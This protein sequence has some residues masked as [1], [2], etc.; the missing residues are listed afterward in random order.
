MIK[1]I[2]RVRT[3]ERKVE[4]ILLNATPREPSQ[5]GSVRRESAAV[6]FVSGGNKRRFHPRDVVKLL[7]AATP[8]RSRNRIRACTCITD[9]LFTSTLSA[10][11]PYYPPRSCLRILPSTDLVSRGIRR[12][13][14]RSSP[15]CS[16]FLPSLLPLALHFS[17]YRHERSSRGNTCI[18]SRGAFGTWRARASRGRRFRSEWVTG[19]HMTHGARFT[20]P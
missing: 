14:L 20:T 12:N 9:L 15:I 2:G 3:R 6:P 8:G 18:I 5:A 1:G 19:A 16:L 4:L 7:S 13:D 17:R 10:V 11:L